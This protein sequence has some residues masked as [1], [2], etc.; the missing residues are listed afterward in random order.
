MPRLS[1]RQVERLVAVLERDAPDPLARIGLLRDALAEAL[2]V[3]VGAAPSWEVLVA[4][5]ARIGDWPA[6]RAALLAAAVSPALLDS[7]DLARVEHAL[8]DAAT[9]LNEERE[10]RPHRA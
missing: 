2:A 10:V 7:A 4:R 1:K 6:E 5:A 9:L 8:W 3:S